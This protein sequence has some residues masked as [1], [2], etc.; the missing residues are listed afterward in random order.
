MYRLLAMMRM[1]LVEIKMLTI[2]VVVIVLLF[3]EI[4]NFISKNIK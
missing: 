2:V 1:S 3:F 4:N